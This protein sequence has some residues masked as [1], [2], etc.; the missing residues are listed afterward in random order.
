[1]H[2]SQYKVKEAKCFGLNKPTSAYRP[3]DDLFEPKRVVSLTLYCELF[4]TTWKK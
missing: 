4:M 1:M 3:D 2:N